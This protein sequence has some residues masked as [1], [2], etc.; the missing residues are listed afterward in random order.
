MTRLF[1]AQARVLALPGAGGH[2]VEVLL[3]TLHAVIDARHALGVTG[4]AQQGTPY[5]A[6]RSSALVVARLARMMLGA[7]AGV[8]RVFVWRH[9][10]STQKCWKWPG[11]RG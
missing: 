5:G 1:H 4:L 8:T 11:L 2:A 9:M 3:N 7:V 6:C 10:T